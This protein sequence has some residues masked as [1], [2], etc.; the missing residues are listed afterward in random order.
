MS[1]LGDIKTGI[2][3]FVNKALHKSYTTTDLDIAIQA[4]L[5]DMANHGLLVGTDTTQTL[6]I[7]DKTLA[8]PTD[9]KK[10]ISITLI[11]GSSNE[12]SPLIKFG[13]GH[14]DYRRLRLNDT[15]NGLTEFYSELNEKFYLWR[16][17]SQAFTVNMEYT[18]YHAQT[19]SDILFGEEF[20]NAVYFGTAFFESIFIKNKEGSDRYGPLYGNEKQ[21]RRLS[22]NTQPSVVRG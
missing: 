11:D 9:F 5:N 3:A 22:F 15:S 16:P 14:K 21:M 12:K 1:A 19:V 7:G 20:R 6:A 8:Y 13:D 4:C 2:L 10:M 18:R 17:P